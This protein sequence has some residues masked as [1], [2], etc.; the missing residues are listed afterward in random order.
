[1][2]AGSD[3]NGSRLQE[4]RIKLRALLCNWNMNE[5][6]YF[7]PHPAVCNSCANF[8]LVEKDC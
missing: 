1:M 3:V 6:L 4:Y 7:K 5:A 8:E 2:R